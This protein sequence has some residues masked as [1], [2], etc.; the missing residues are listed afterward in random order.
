MMC[1]S[2]NVKFF[3]VSVMFLHLLLLYLYYIMSFAFLG[4][5]SFI[6]NGTSVNSF[7]F[8]KITKK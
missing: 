8:I 4:K 6:F 7:C 3:G 1:T 5:S 2:F